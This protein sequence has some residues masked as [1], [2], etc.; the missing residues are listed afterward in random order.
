MSDGAVA[1]YLNGIVTAR[2]AR[3]SY[4]VLRNVDFD[5][6][7]EEHRKRVNSLLYRPSGRKL[8]PDAFE[9]MLAKGTKVS[10]DTEV[11]VKMW[12]ECNLDQKSKLQNVLFTLYCYKGNKF[13]KEAPAFWDEDSSERSTVPHVGY[14]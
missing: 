4:G 2:I 5:P 9:V 6:N 8:V 11:S 10:D 3:F 7:K 14:D 12:K 1:S 13:K